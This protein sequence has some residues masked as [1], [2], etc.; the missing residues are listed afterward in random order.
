MITGKNIYMIGIKGVGMTSLAIV[1]HRMAN[2][3]SGSDVEKRFITDEVLEKYG[4][5]VHQGFDSSHISSNIDL[6]IISGVFANDKNVEFAKLKNGNIPI[7]THAEALGMIMDDFTTRI[8]VCGSHGKTTTSAM[9]A[10]IFSES[11]QKGAHQIGVPHFSDQDGGAYNGTDYFI[12]EA[13]EYANK[14]NIDNTPRFT[15]QHPTILVCTN[16]DFDHPDIYASINEVQEAFKK[17]VTTTVEAGGNIVFCS[18]DLPT[19]KVIQGI[20]Y[21]KIYS[22]GISKNADLV[23]SDINELPGKNSFKATFRG[24]FLGEIVLQTS[25]MHNILNA[26]AA[27]LASYLAKIDIKTITEG[28]LKFAG[29]ARRYQRIFQL[30][31]TYVYDDYAH[32][33]K[34]ISAVIDATR[35]AFPEHRIIIIFQP[36]TFSRSNALGSEFQI[37]LQK[38]DVAFC[39]E[40]FSS[41]RETNKTLADAHLGTLFTK[42]EALL[43]LSKEVLEKTVIIT[44]GAGDVY[45][46]HPSIIKCIQNYYSTHA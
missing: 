33:P 2:K 42:D 45:S 4:I 22:F 38:A 30:N 8:S 9:L 40:V 25:G 35:H 10:T 13:D 20:S 14:P 32:H 36:H 39:L 26:A 15:F 17:F 29:S 6:I 34:E 16:V 19:S 1:L 23:I 5:E 11:G 7:M 3:V 18:D 31:D 21:D 12:A 46:M 28:L 27:L 44:M 24:E 43:S 41:E 37:A